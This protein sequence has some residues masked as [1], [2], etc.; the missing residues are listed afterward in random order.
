MK[1][2]GLQRLSY[3]P[4]LFVSRCSKADLGPIS[5]HS[6]HDHSHD[7]ELPNLVQLPFQKIPSSG[8]S[9]FKG[10]FE[11]MGGG[12]TRPQVESG[13]EKL[14]FT[15]KGK[16]ITKIY[17]DR[18]RQLTDGGQYQS[19]GLR[20]M[21]VLDQENGAEYVKLEVYSVPDLSR[22]VFEDAI[23]GRTNCILRVEQNVNDWSRD[24]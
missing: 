15:P 14:N 24:L 21:F 13:Y 8:A 12:R 19:V 6:H 7:S 10:A 4:Q 16:Q 2:I 23:K 22:P 18:L 11:A 20:S 17:Q 3:F 5:S 1:P 9:A